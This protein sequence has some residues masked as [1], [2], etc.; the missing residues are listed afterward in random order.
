MSQWQQQNFEE[1][2]SKGRDGGVQE[3]GEEKGKKAGAKLGGQRHHPEHGPD[4]RQRVNIS[5]QVE[6]RGYLGNQVFSQ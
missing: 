6:V 2:R 3:E 5:E 4:S 1:L